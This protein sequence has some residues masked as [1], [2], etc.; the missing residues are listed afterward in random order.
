MTHESIARHNARYA[1][2]YRFK[3]VSCGGRKRSNNTRLP[4]TP[5]T[6]VTS[7]TLPSFPTILHCTIPPT[8]TIPLWKS[9]PES[10]AGPLTRPTQLNARAAPNSTHRHS[11]SHSSGTQLQSPP[12]VKSPVKILDARTGTQDFPKLSPI[13]ISTYHLTHLISRKVSYNM[14]VQVNG[15]PTMEI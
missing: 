2:R 7:T 14:S 5:T 10:H 8:P 6:S 12:P 13:Y 4:L 11:T 1:T 3:T 9:L 15:P